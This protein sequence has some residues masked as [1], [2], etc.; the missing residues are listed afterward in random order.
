MLF[1]IDHDIEVAGGTAVEAGFSFSLNAQSGAVVHAGRDPDFQ[2]FFFAHAA[3]ALA[4]LA[5]V[6][7]DSA[8]PVALAA[9]SADR[10]KALLIAHLA[11]AVAG[12]AADRVFALWQFRVLRRRRTCPDA[13]S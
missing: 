8:G 7:D 1:H 9:G 11:G 4:G 6:A 5:G 3:S 12:R 10:K 13:G 2:H